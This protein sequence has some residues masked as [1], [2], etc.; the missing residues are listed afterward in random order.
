MLVS[1][2]LNQYK[3]ESGIVLVFTKLARAPS[4][5]VDLDEDSFC[6]FGRRVDE[7][8]SWS[9]YFTTCLIDRRA[10]DRNAEDESIA[11]NTRSITTPESMNSRL[12]FRC[13]PSTTDKFPIWQP[14]EEAVGLLLDKNGSEF[15]RRL[16]TGELEAEVLKKRDGGGRSLLVHA[17]IAD[18]VKAV[19]FL[20]KRGLPLMDRDNYG[21][22][23]LH[24][25]VISDAFK[26]VRHILS[27]PRISSE[28]APFLLGDNN[29]VTPLHIAATKQSGAMLKTLLEFR[30]DM[31]ACY[32]AIDRK[33]RSPFHYA[34]MHASVECVEVLMDGRHGFPMD[35]RDDFGLTP[36]II[37]AGVR[38]WGAADIVRSLGCRK[39]TSWAMRS[40][41]G[42]TALHMAVLADNIPVIEVLLKEL[43]CSPNYALDNEKRTPLHYAALHGRE[44]A[45]A[46]LL[47]H[48]ASNMIRDQHEV[49]AAH[50]AA[51]QDANTLDVILRSINYDLENV[52]DKQGRSIFMWAVLAGNIKTVE[53]C[54]RKNNLII[55]RSETDKKG[56]TALHLTVHMGNLELCKLLMQQGWNPSDSDNYGA[57]PLHIAAGRGHT[58]IVRFLVT[59]GADNEAQDAQGRTPVFHACLGGKSLTLE[60]MIKSLQFSIDHRDVLKSTPLH[61]AAFAGHHACITTL[62]KAGAY[63]GDLDAD[64]YT[65]LHVAAERG[66]VECCKALI[67]GG[68]AVNSLAFVEDKKTLDGKVQLTPVSCALLNGHD[69]VVEYLRSVDG[70]TPEELRTVAARII[71]RCWRRH[72]AGDH[73]PAVPQPP[74]QQLSRN[75]HCIPPGRSRP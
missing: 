54:L 3:I 58:D 69:K 17:A 66:K 56:L 13:S 65:P 71:Q 60:T 14:L 53:Y 72:L 12:N 30:R 5:I 22:T 15:E 32:R 28:T 45:A 64:S 38:A 26:V 57:T 62:I 59:A 73:S 7:A 37:A 10:R 6:Y 11:P 27:Q 48:G 23:P 44:R 19:V 47:E 24:Y 1:M 16:K 46:L 34:A 20:N 33:G 70:M 63:V 40:S 55:H 29:G 52:N 61:A 50:Y 39:N 21:M 43:L 25:A 31:D 9:C 49:T 51:Q 35:Q 41:A 67:Q 18:Q 36:M 75:I 8:L 2:N 68:A 4:P 42:V 74:T